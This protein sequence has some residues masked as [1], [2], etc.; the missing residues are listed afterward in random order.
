[1][2]YLPK[3]VPIVVQLLFPKLIWKVNTNEKTIYLTF[4]DGPTPEI[5]DWVLDQLAT[6]NAKA[7]FFLHW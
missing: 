2:A 1:M 4:D 7:T 3:K 5:T 6:F